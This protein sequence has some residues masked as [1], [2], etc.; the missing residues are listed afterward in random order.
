MVLQ[1]FKEGCRFSEIFLKI[2]VLKTCKTLSDFH[3]K[4]CRNFKRGAILKYLVP[5]L[6]RTYDIFVG[7]KL[8]PLG[9]NHFPF[10]GKN[11]LKCCCK[12]C[13]KEQPFVSCLLDELSLSNICTR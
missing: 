10:Q 12:T 9:K 5:Y 8:K 2:K 1:F 13:L 4:T 7:F 11:K 6:R 3:I